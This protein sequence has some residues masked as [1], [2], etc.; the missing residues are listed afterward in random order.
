MSFEIYPKRWTGW[1][2]ITWTR[3][4]TLFARARCSLLVV[5]DWGVGRS[6]KPGISTR[7]RYR[8]HEEAIMLDGQVGSETPLPAAY[9]QKHDM[10]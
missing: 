7:P 3:E 4:Q 1:K 6:F 9:P 5:N 10:N 8:C 2:S